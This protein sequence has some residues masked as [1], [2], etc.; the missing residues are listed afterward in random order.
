MPPVRSF[1]PLLFLLL[2][3]PNPLQAAWETV[4]VDSD[5]RIGSI[6]LSGDLEAYEKQGDIFLYRISSGRRIQVTLDADDPEDLILGLGRETLWYWAHDSQSGLNRLHRYDVESDLDA[7]ILEADSRIDA[8]KGTAESGRAIICKDHD[9]FLVEGDRVTQVTFSGEGLPKQEA[10]LSGDYLVWK[11]VAGTPGVYVT[12]LPTKETHCVFDDDD[13]PVSL[14]VSGMHAAWVT[15]AAQGQYWIL[16][17][18]LDTRAPRVVGSSEERIPWQL[19]IDAPRL[20]WLK[21]T[22]PVWLL[23]ETNLEDQAEQLLY[24]SELSMHTPR[25]SGNRILFIRDN[26]P[27]EEESCSELNI[28]NPETGGLTQLTYFGRDSIVS[29]PQIDAGRVAF[30]RESWG[31]D[32]VAEAYAGLETPGPRCGTLS[33]TGGLNAGVNLALVF[34]PLALAPWFHRRRIRRSRSR[35]PNATPSKR[36]PP[37]PF[38]RNVSSSP[39]TQSNSRGS[40]A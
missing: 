2:L 12:H 29:S 20:V 19:A 28:L 32:T 18:R 25:V 39:T 23:M 38:P 21:K 31:F 3:A 35:G 22:G 27:A 13:P 16:A 4:K 30:R 26:C 37:T 6:A 9:W 7:W 8:H 1:G 11:A 14:W 24:F 40:G 36:L 34:A 10:W 33:R 5:A 15:G 17:C